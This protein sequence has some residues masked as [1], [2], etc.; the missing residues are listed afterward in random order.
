MEMVPSNKR[1]RELYEE[2]KKNVKEADKE[3]KHKTNEVPSDVVK[4]SETR[5]DSSQ[6]KKI[7]IEEMNSCKEDGKSSDGKLENPTKKKGKRL[8]I[9]EVENTDEILSEKTESIRT[10]EGTVENTENDLMQ[11]DNKIQNKII[12]DADIKLSMNEKDTTSEKLSH[13]VESK[14]CN[15]DQEDGMARDN[16]KSQRVNDAVD[17][18]FAC[19]E[20]S[21]LRKAMDSTMM[22]NNATEGFQKSEQILPVPDEIIG[23]KNEGNMFYKA[24]QYAEAER[25][26]SEAID[27]LRESKNWS[28]H[29]SIIL[30][31]CLS[32]NS[33]N[34]SLSKWSQNIICFFDL[35][36]V[37]AMSILLLYC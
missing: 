18:K 24:G 13:F 37:K 1:A 20:N 28:L 16:E 4:E 30:S 25:K 15:S 3:Q 8:K 21:D 26:Y 9:I 33:L 32:F 22:Q 12:P 6:G 27:R 34:S 14:L 2:V 11:S 35:Q 31:I 19:K 29:S 10:D 23:I 5:I 7:L 17:E 36:M